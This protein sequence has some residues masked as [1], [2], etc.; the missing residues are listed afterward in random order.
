MK[1]IE[2]S[3]FPECVDISLNCPKCGELL[4]ERVYIPSPDFLSEK[5]TFSGTRNDDPFEISCSCGFSVNGI[6][7]G[8]SCGCFIYLYIDDDYQVNID[9]NYDDYEW[10]DNSKNK[11]PYASFTNDMEKVYQLFLKREKLEGCEDFFINLLYSNLVTCLEVFLSDTLASN[12]FSQKEFYD[13]FVKTY[14]PFIETKISLNTIIDRYLKLD[15]TVKQSLSEIMYH[16]IPK[17]SQIYEQVLGIK[18]SSFAEIQRIVVKRHDLVH[19]NGKDRNGDVISISEKD[20]EDAYQKIE[21][22]VDDIN[23]NRKIRSLFSMS[24]HQ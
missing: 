23:N 10:Y 20:F 16:N 7:T 11:D 9:E 18:F 17:V 21:S 2:I 6:A 5:D 14:K 4:E 13:K 3:G 19:R 8:S 24:L 22:F 1:T 12:I 15:K